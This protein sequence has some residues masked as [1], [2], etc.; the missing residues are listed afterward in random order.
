LLADLDKLQVS[1]STSTATKTASSSASE[2]RA[3]EP[4]ARA[5]ALLSALGDAKD[6]S[7]VLARVAD[8]LVQLADAAHADDY[9]EVAL[10]VLQRL[11]VD[12]AAEA[13]VWRERLALKSLP[14]KAHDEALL[15]A[16]ASSP[17]VAL[18]SPH[19][20]N[21]LA[22]YAAVQQAGATVA[23]GVCEV[24]LARCKKDCGVHAVVHFAAV[25]AVR[26][27][28]VGYI[29]ARAEADGDDDD[30][31]PRRAAD[32]FAALAHCAIAGQWRTAAQLAMAV[33]HCGEVGGG[34]VSGVAAT[35]A[36]LRIGEQRATQRCQRAAERGDVPAEKAWR[37]DAALLLAAQATCHQ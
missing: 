27:A 24:L 2:F 30:D 4:K 17:L 3:L 29:V 13:Q 21:R 5:T 28:L 35:A 1:S 14:N 11:Y 36:L 7:D 26:R 19:K 15:A 20:A 18:T 12:D 31:A 23:D 8:P 37:D 32:A 6:T 22:G 33:S 34:L 10:A 25:G 16:G 9:S